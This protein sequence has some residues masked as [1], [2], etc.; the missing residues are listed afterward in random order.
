MSRA[1]V[2]LIT[3][4]STN[5]DLPL[6]VR[7]DGGVDM[8]S[9]ESL[10]IMRYPDGRICYFANMFVLELYS[11]GH[12]LTNR[13]GTLRTYMSLLSH[14]IKYA[15][16]NQLTFPQFTNNRF[17]LFMRSLDGFLKTGT[18]RSPN[19]QIRIICQSLDFLEYVGK[20]IDKP[21]FVSKTGIIRAHRIKNFNK[22]SNDYLNNNA[23]SACR[24]T[25]WDVENMPNYMDPGR[26]SAMGIG[27]LTALKKATMD[28]SSP[29]LAQRNALIIEL[30]HA[31]GSRRG[32]T[33]PIKTNDIKNALGNSN[34]PNCLMLKTLKHGQLEYREV[35]LPKMTLE[36]ANEYIQSS[37]R[38]KIGKTIGPRNDH[39]YLFVSERTGAPLSTNTITNI[40][41]KL[42]KHAG[43]IEK[44]H[45]HML[46]HL[47]IHEHMD[48][49]VFLLENSIDTSVHSPQRIDLIAS[50]KLMQR[51]GH[52]SFK[53][54]KH[55]L[56]QYYEDLTKLLLPDK[57]ARRET[58][59]RLIPGQIPAMLAVIKDMDARQ[60][61]PFVERILTALQA[62]LG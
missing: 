24:T 5:F 11:E 34:T 12:S 57:L 48:E 3:S 14:I 20:I 18:K 46:R 6:V 60:I 38:S 50:L 41:G 23:Y 19:Q 30:M 9:A 36:M 40:F 4:V 54:L 58:A 8:K 37:R 26:G 28:A 42:R 15:Y 25:R 2:R 61:R 45:P 59:L 1:P 55:Y 27:A 21:N 13:G 22:E 56:E 10:P 33:S 51:T 44:A 35:V 16:Y 7:P 47:F 43:I 31:T 32:E 62:D 39:G 17:Q 29:F 49:L 52:R 53:G